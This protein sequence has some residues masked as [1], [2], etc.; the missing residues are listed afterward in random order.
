MTIEAFVQIRDRISEKIAVL[1][2][3]GRLTVN[4]H[5]G[6]LKDA[7]TDAVRRG[8]LHVVL[9]LGGVHYIDSTRLGEII[10]AHVTLARQ[11]GRLALAATPERLIEL[12]TLSGLND[13]FE[14]FDTVD[15][16]LASLKALDT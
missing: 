13:V 9:D 16:A 12:L 8:A 6:V 2:L 4:D 3:S 5:A 7:V 1:E 10:A 14:R 15:E 11:E